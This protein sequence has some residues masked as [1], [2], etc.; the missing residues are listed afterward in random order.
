MK[1]LSVRVQYALLSIAMIVAL[2]VAPSQQ[3]VGASGGDGGGKNHQIRLSDLAGTSAETGQGS[4]VLCFDSTGA[5][6][7]CGTS[8]SSTVPFTFLALGPVIRDFSGNA[9][10]SFTQTLADVPPNANPPMVS[11]FQ[12]GAK[13]TSY[14]P[15]TGT[16][17]CSFTSFTGA[18]CVGAA[19]T[20]GTVIGTGTCHYTASE[21]G[22]RIDS[23]LTTLSGIGAFSISLVDHRE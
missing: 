6:V 18:T 23:V 3:A 11:P 9:C 14:D 1:V 8:G 7:A 21:G 10:G 4:I 17:D 2:G 13:T 5:Q 15:R 16:G 19:A 12:V 22:D 20:G